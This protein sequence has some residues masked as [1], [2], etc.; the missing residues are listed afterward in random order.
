[1]AKT[2]HGLEEILAHEVSMAGGFGVKPAKRAVYFSANLETLYRCNLVCSTALR[3]LVELKFYNARNDDELYNFAK[4][5][6][7]TEML[8]PSQTFLVSSTVYSPVFKHSHFAALKIKDAIVDTFRDASLPRPNVDTSNPDVVVHVH[9]ANQNVSIMLDSSGESLHKRGYRITGM[10]APLNEVLAAGM[11]RLSNW[12]PETEF[13]D[14]MCGSGTLAIEAALLASNT[15]VNYRRSSFSFQNWPNYKH[16]LWEQIFN[17]ELEKVAPP[18]APIWGADISSRAVYASKDNAEAAGMSEYITFKKADISET[19][20]TQ[21]EGVI[22]MNPP[23]GERLQPAE[24]NDLYAKIGTQLKHYY[25]GFSAW[26]LS[27]NLNALKFVGLRP[28]QRLSL[29]NGALQTKFMHF[30]LYDGSKKTKK[31]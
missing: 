10:P 2:H 26:I 27:S 18:K 14:P 19:K 21:S 30:S 7:W 28:S 23:Y 3:F 5:V 6:R 11:I 15:P 17:K 9:I 29:F 20:P 22:M 4:R 12:N 1:M 25:S 8:D 31:Q 16:A 13:I 24:I